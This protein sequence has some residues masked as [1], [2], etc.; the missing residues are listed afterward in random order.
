MKKIIAILGLILSI[1]IVLYGSSAAVRAD[2]WGPTEEDQKREHPYGIQFFFESREVVVPNGAEFHAN[3]DHI[4]YASKGW[5]HVIQKTEVDKML[6][7]GEITYESLTTDIVKVDSQGRLTAVKQGIAKVSINWPSWEGAQ[8]GSD[9]YGSAEFVVRVY[10][11]KAKLNETNVRLKV[12]K[13]KL[14][15]VK[16]FPSNVINKTK[17]TINNNS[18]A[19]LV[20]PKKDRVMI[21]GLKKGKATLK[22]KVFGKT[23]RCKV[24]VK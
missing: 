16:N 24:T 15:R 9:E 7:R 14:I 23:F 2:N 3:L 20:K 12:K 5:A 22:A 1:G 11:C 21:K 13:A 8:P 10:K 19:K 18:V 6:K 4:S 17:F